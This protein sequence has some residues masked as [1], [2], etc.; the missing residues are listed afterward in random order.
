MED[1]ICAVPHGLS[2]DSDVV[3]RESESISKRS[4]R[5]NAKEVRVS[6]GSDVD[7]KQCMILPVHLETL[8]M[9][10]DIGSG[11]HGGDSRTHDSARREMPPAPKRG[12]K[13][14]QPPPV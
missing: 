9:K 12:R 5:S 14:V 4:L 2:T 8:D 11:R 7:E 1:K 10:E 13:K 6:N 3:K